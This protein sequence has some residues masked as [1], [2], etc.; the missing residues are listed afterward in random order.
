MPSTF[1]VIGV[2]ARGSA[3]ARGVGDSLIAFKD[4]WSC[5]LGSLLALLPLFFRQLRS[6]RPAYLCRADRLQL[7]FAVCTQKR[8]FCGCRICAPPSN[9]EFR[10]LRL[11]LRSRNRIHSPAVWGTIMGDVHCGTGREPLADSIT[12]GPCS[13]SLAPFVG[14][15]F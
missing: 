7:D 15:K 5:G 3:V 6:T 2:A 4:C 13:P 1:I 12:N 9:H 11:H 14:R 8:Y 10:H